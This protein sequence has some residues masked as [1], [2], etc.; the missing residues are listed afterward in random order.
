MRNEKFQYRD[1][2]VELKLSVKCIFKSEHTIGI[3][4]PATT[5]FLDADIFLVAE[6]EI[7][8]ATVTKL[9]LCLYICYLAS[10]R[11]RTG[12]LYKKTPNTNFRLFH[13]A[14]SS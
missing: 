3:S 1:L 2:L 14:P 13:L 12:I 9:F 8:I 7:D 11:Q 6:S 4:L 10:L 5:P